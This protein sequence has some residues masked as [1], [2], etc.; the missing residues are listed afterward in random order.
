MWASP[1]E[2]NGGVGLLL[3]ERAHG[4]TRLKV[5]KKR[6]AGRSSLSTCIFYKST[7]TKTFPGLMYIQHIQ[8]V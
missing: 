5:K 8:N 6:I 4:S 7:I 3:V 2:G 1:E